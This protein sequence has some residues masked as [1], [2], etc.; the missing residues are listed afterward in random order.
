[1]AVHFFEEEVYLFHYYQPRY[2]CPLKLFIVYLVMQMVLSLDCI[3]FIVL[4][5]LINLFNSLILL[6]QFRP[7]P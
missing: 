3:F 7:W 4:L 6:E 2:Q 1:M 5:L